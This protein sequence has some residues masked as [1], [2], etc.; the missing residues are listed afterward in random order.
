MRH[1]V[2]GGGGF[3]GSHLADALIARGDEVLVLDDFSTGRPENLEHLTEAPGFE[4][5]KGSILD[6]GLVN[7]CV[8]SADWVFHLASAVGVQLIVR[9]PLQSLLTNMRGNDEVMSAAAK[10]RKRLLFTSTSEVY[11]KNGAGALGEDSDR[12]LGSP[13]KSRW[14]YATSKALG[15]ALAHAYYTERGAAMVVVRLFNTVGRRQT[16]AYGMVLPRFVGQALR[17][18][19]LTVYGNGTQTRCFVHV[20]DTV[21]ALVQLLDEEAAPGNVYN[22]GSPEPVAIIDLARRVLEQTESQSRVTLV[23]Y[24]EAYE[25]GFEELGHRIPDTTALSELTGW[26]P[27]RALDETIADVVAYE[28]NR[29]R[30]TESAALAN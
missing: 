18:H 16:G 1:L 6:G 26:A 5:L 9:D 21:R 24:E 7:D 28:A 23:P 15:E 25:P 20:A 3:I 27:T 22:I 14:G 12:V 30:A 17:G 19:D 13:S 2:T 8:E 11:G 10:H 4:L 29:L